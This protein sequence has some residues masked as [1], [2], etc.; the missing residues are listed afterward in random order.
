MNLNNPKQ[1]ADLHEMYK[2]ALLDE[3][4]ANNRTEEFI[5]DLIE[6]FNFSMHT[7]L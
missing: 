7:A 4:S 2:Q 5:K 6:V 3:F 1:V